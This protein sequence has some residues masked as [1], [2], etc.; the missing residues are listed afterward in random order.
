MKGFLL[1]KKILICLHS[2]ENVTFQWLSCVSFISYVTNSLKIGVASLICE[3]KKN[4]RTQGF[5]LSLQI[6]QK[7]GHNHQVLEEG[8]LFV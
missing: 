6:M 7:Q 4:L 2:R 8:K 3:V 5:T 1:N